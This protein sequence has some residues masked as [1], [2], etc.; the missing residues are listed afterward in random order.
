MDVISFS[1]SAGVTGAAGCRHFQWLISLSTFFE[2]LQGNYLC[3]IYVKVRPLSTIA[4]TPIPNVCIGQLV[5]DSNQSRMLGDVFK[6]PLIFFPNSPIVTTVPPNSLSLV[7]SSDSVIDTLFNL[8]VDVDFY[9]SD[10]PETVY[11][12]IFQ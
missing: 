9:Y 3:G 11:P 10:K 7:F 1:T 2:E 4:T 5:V 8:A 12:Y 6:N